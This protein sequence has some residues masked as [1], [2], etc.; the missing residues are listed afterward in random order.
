MLLQNNQAPTLSERYRFKWQRCPQF[1]NQILVGRK[2]I[3]I[4][5]IIA[6]IQRSTQDSPQ[7]SPNWRDRA[8][9]HDVLVGRRRNRNSISSLLERNG[10]FLW[11]PWELI[12]RKYAIRVIFLFEQ[13]QFGSRKLTPAFVSPPKSTTYLY[14]D[15]LFAFAFNITLK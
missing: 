13:Q 2:N 11:N 1:L 9:R 5:F 4:F 12:P 7:R 15:K 3:M 10:L 14:N 8:K 6:D